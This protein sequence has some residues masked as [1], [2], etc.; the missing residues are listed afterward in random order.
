MM[1]Q[2][3]V[4]E[5]AGM[6]GYLKI[7]ERYANQDIS[8][9]NDLMGISMLALLMTPWAMIGL[10]L[11]A[12]EASFMTQGILIACIITMIVAIPQALILLSGNSDTNPKHAI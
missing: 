9:R 11:S 3:D 12:F 6:A 7:E 10:T 4:V 8:L 2:Q 5:E 1:K